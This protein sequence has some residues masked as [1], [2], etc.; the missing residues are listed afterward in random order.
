MEGGE[1]GKWKELGSRDLWDEG[2][3]GGGEGKV[4][5]DGEAWEV[6]TYVKREGLEAE[7]RVTSGVEGEVRRIVGVRQGRCQS[8]CLCS[9]YLSTYTT[10]CDYHWS[11][12]WPTTSC[13]SPINQQS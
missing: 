6:R 12:W 10:V 13:T 4:R 5:W 8:G 9:G 1:G 3:R 7:N 11:W 2:G